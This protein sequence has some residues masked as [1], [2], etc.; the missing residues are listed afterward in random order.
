MFCSLGEEINGDTFR[1]CFQTTG[2]LD[3]LGLNWKLFGF[4]NQTFA[5]NIEDWIDLD[6]LSGCLQACLGL[7]GNGFNLDGFGSCRDTLSLLD[8]N[9]LGSDQL[10]HGDGTLYGFFNHW[11]NLDHLRCN[12]QA[13]LFDLRNGND[14]DGFSS[15]LKA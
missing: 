9:F 12:L 7:H 11:C 8:G 4:N 6:C 15:G 3:K 2:F 5:A 10:W 14:A 1:L 13:S